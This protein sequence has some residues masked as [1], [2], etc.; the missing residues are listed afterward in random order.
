MAKFTKLNPR[1]VLLGRERAAVDARKLYVDAIKSGAAGKIELQRGEKPTAVKRLLS[2]ASKE[3]GIK[4]R[5]TWTDG[6]KRMLVWKRV[7]R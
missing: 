1:D 2:E 3:A 7:G 4:V 6:R 5:S